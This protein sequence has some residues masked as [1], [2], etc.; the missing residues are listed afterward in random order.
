MKLLNSIIVLATQYFSVWSFL[1]SLL[2]NSQQT[3]VLASSVE[4]IFRLLSVNPDL[5]LRDRK[6][7]DLEDLSNILKSFSAN[8][9]I[10][11][12]KSYLPSLCLKKFRF[13]LILCHNFN[14]FD[15][16]SRNISA[17]NFEPDGYFVL[18]FI[19]ITSEEIEKVFET[20]WKKSF[21]N[22]NVLTQ[23][24]MLTFMPF[25]QGRCKN[26]SPIIVSKYIGESWTS[27]DFFPEKFSNMYNCTFKASALQSTP[28]VIRNIFRNGSYEMDGIEVVMMRETAKSLNFQ[29]EIES[30][31][32]DHGL[33]FEGNDSA[34]GNIKHA[35]SGSSDLILGSYYLRDN[36]AKYLSYSQVY[37]FDPTLMV[38]AG[39]PTYS[40]LEKLLRPFSVW[41]FLG[42][43]GMLLVGFCSIS[44]LHKLNSNDNSLKLLNILA[45]FFGVSM[46]TLPRRDS[47]KILLISFAFFCIIIRTIYQGSLFKLMHTDDRKQ[48]ITSIDEM[49]AEKFI[50]HSTGSFAQS[51]T[52]VKYYKW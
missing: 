23:S 40:P 51:I 2:G 19:E 34:T 44:L 16:L 48:G 24:Q 29:I 17:N 1:P 8:G 27:S 43:I 47:L 12:V 41:L 21:Y 30:T 13:S 36:R 5:I 33:I 7:D 20:L 46:S 28:A 4:D 9:E 42:L 14:T 50:F 25:Q 6:T 10:S 49:V 26:T 35:I 32:N 37:R 18:S 22:I 11:E 52:D 39:N 45:I 31:E 3:S 15:T 38:A